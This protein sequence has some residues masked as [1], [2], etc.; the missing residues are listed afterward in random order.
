MEQLTLRHISPKCVI[1]PCKR[2]VTVKGLIIPTK[3]I[4]LKTVNQISWQ[5][6]RGTEEA[7]FCKM[8]LLLKLNLLVYWVSTQNCTL[9]WY[10]CMHSWN[11]KGVPYR[12]CFNSKHNYIVFILIWLQ[13]LSDLVSECLDQAD[14]DGYHSI[15]FPPFG[16]GYLSYPTPRVADIMLE[17]IEDFTSRTLTTVYI[18]IYSQESSCFQVNRQFKVSF[19]LCLLQFL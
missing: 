7:K 5:Q 11:L 3:L 10:D 9:R 19:L 13:L 16:T 4:W 17:C 14:T 1:L 8:I 12:S 15:A 2:A 18:V 6:N